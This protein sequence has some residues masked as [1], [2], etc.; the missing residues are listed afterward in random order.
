MKIQRRVI[1]C[2]TGIVLAG[3]M[4]LSPMQVPAQTV[5][6]PG[7]TVDDLITGIEETADAGSVPA[8]F[9]LQQNY[10]NP[11]NPSTT[12]RYVLPE[13]ARVRLT[14]YNILGQQVKVLADGIEG[15]GLHSIMWNGR[16]EGGS[17]AASGIYIY[18]LKAGS[19]VQ[20]RK[21]ALF[22]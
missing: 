16:N 2:A 18:R 10:P 8:G 22:K 17:P 19:F 11:F 4:T 1:A 13:A 6:D 5:T 12:I 9:R 20:S 7:E 3:F 21:M 15:Q 14:V